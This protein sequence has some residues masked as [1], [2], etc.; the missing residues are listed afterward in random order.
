MVGASFCERR[1]WREHQ[2]ISEGDRARRDPGRVTAASSPVSDQRQSE[3]D[4][5]GARSRPHCHR[6]CAVFR[7]TGRIFK[8]RPKNKYE[9]V[10]QIST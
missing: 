2:L 5:E 9:G 8:A 7:E 1:H 10:A 3:V 6:H 4:L